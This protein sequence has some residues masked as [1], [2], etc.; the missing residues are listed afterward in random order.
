MEKSCVLVFGAVSAY[1]MQ[2]KIL[3]IL[4]K[5]NGVI[6]RTIETKLIQLTKKRPLTLPQNVSTQGSTQQNPV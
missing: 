2:T 6:L 3:K 4:V 1:M 5:T